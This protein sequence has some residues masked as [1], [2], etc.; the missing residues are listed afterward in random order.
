MT[1][2]TNAAHASEVAEPGGS[3]NTAATVTY[4]QHPSAMDKNLS[5][6]CA[7]N[8]NVSISVFPDQHLLWKKKG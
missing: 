6:D 7:V 5:S 8:K 1:G 2:G 3:S 4:P